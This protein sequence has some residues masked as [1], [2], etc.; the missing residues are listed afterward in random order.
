MGPPILTSEALLL[1][2][3]GLSIFGFG[4]SWT[5][6]G[7]ATPISNPTHRAECAEAESVLW[8]C[9]VA[10]PSRALVKSVPDTSSAIGQTSRVLPLAGPMN[11]CPHDG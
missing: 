4:L 8:R 9:S 1:T 3:P 5:Q 6:P 2:S 11:E 10:P 7:Q